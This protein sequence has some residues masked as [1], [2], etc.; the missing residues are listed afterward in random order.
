MTG[1]LGSTLLD[2]RE[3]RGLSL[4]D[5]A[6]ASGDQIS[7][8]GLSRIER[9]VTR[10][11]SRPVLAAL[12]V[13]LGIPMSRLRAAQGQTGPVPTEPFVL[14]T[15]ASD[16]NARERRTVLAVVDTLLAAHRSVKVP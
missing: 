7:A 1:S 4:R 6:Q 15:R 2:A 13:A 3:Q 16:L 5:V 14:P 10:Q 9:G 8:S 11:V 12:S